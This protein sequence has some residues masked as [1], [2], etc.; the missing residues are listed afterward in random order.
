MDQVYPGF[1]E[2]M[3]RMQEGGQYRFSMP[4][5]LA[6]GANGAPQGFPKGSNLNF[7]V[8][9]RKIVPRRRGAAPA[10]V[11][12]SSRRRS[13]NRPTVD[14][15]RPFSLL[16]LVPLAEIDEHDFQGRK[17]RVGEQ[18]AQNPE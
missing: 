4:Q 3:T 13:S 7:E 16:R 5:S 1:A 14:D 17:D 15:V 6:F 18:H 8:R 9:V 11:R 10:A 12:S 2:A